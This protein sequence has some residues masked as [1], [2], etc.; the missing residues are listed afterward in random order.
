M[1]DPLFKTK[2]VKIETLG[3]YLSHI[4]EQLNMDL[5]TVS[6][7]TQIK[8]KFL[9]QIEA[10][11]WE[12]LPADVYIRGFLKSLAKAYRIEERLLLDQ[13][14]KEHGFKQIKKPLP[15]T[16]F[17][18]FTFTPRTIVLFVGLIAAVVLVWYI[19]AQVSSVLVPPKLVLTE[20]GGNG[21]V[22]GNSIVFSGSA[23][24][25]AEVYI[26]GQSVLL[27][28]NGEFTENLIL[29]QGVNVIEVVA[30]N[31]FNK[32]SR[33]VRTISSEAVERTPVEQ[34]PVTIQVDVGPESAW[35]YVEADG[36]TMQ[37]GTMLPNSSKIFTAKNEILLTTSDA[38]ST[39]VIYN[40]NDLGKLGQAGEV[41]RNIEF[42][43]AK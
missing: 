3:S 21:T 6:M 40:G 8:P 11:K 39:N 34:Q 5:K 41:I 18:T 26:N 38:G 36:L 37:R 32:E 2:A 20:P 15:K 10:G 35:I 14:D 42:T 43:S 28:K 9:E 16:P 31:K 4:R 33:L 12:D 25:G 17:I 22:I 13:Y 23:E 30:R 1:T 29:S 24:I 27:D 7:L 19:I